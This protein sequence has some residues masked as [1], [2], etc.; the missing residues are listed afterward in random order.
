MKK[1]HIILFILF[2]ILFHNCSTNNETELFEEVVELVPEFD[3]KDY[4]SI[5]LHGKI[6][7]LLP[8]YL[9]LNEPDVKSLLIEADHTSKEEHVSLFEISKSEFTKITEPGGKKYKIDT[10]FSIFSAKQIKK[11]RD[12]LKS[13]NSYKLTLS[14]SVNGMR[15]YSYEIEGSQFGFPLEQVFFIRFYEGKDNFYSMISWTTKNSKTK[16]NDAVKIM[17][18]TLKEI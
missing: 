14:N 18:L 5:S 9:S 6:K 17:Q 1:A 16:F 2:G 15:S 11:F 3:A 12:V 13:E 7:M 8:N 4:D 10:L